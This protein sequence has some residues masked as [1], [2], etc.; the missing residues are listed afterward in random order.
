MTKL[1]LKHQRKISALPIVQALKVVMG[2]HIVI[3]VKQQSLELDP[4][5]FM[6][7]LFL[8]TRI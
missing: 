2:I 4:N 1:F 5:S 6:P 7:L 3:L 8:E